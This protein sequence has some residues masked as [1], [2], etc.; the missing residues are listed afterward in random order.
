MKEINEKLKL[1]H[2][3]IKSRY[4][5]ILDIKYDE[6][7]KVT[8]FVDIVFDYIKLT[9]EFLPFET[10]STVWGDYST[11]SGIF[12]NEEDR[13]KGR[14]Y[15]RIIEEEINDVNE[16]LSKHNKELKIPYIIA[17]NNWIPARDTIPQGKDFF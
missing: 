1:I 3:I 10:R 5:Y 14:K 11:P 8:L 15:G 13:E 6:E 2:K 17:I 16:L 7:K 12:A 9:E 4:P